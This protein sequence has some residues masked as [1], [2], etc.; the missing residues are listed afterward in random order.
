MRP[1]NFSSPIL[2]HLPR[3]PRVLATCG[4]CRVPGGLDWGPIFPCGSLFIFLLS[5]ASSFTWATSSVKS[6][7][8]TPTPTLN[9]SPA[10]W[11]PWWAE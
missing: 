5:S 8:I 10:R 4:S 3:S 1:G 2:C 7:L 11:A 9:R 6:S